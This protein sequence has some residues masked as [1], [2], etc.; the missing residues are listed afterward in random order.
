MSILVYHVIM[1]LQTRIEI[2]QCYYACGRCPTAALRQFKLQRDLVKDPFSLSG[3]TRL[4]AKFEE[5]GSVL[6][7]PRSGRP[8]VDDDTVQEV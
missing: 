1:D 3:I 2:V 6:D 7:K 8:S 5:T 4:I